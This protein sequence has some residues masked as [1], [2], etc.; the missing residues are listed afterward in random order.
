MKVFFEK[1]IGFYPHAFSWMG[2]SNSVTI[3]F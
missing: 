1:S 3:L 2:S